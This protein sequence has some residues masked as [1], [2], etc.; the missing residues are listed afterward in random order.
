MFY[1]GVI[2]ILLFWEI[3]TPVLLEGF[4]MELEW[5]H[6]FLSLEDSSQYYYY[7]YY[8]S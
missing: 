6:V 2:I 3:F 8:Y 4:S 1:T 5:Q 7:Y